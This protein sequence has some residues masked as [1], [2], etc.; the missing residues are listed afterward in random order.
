MSSYYNASS[1]HVPAVLHAALPRGE[2][3]RS[4]LRGSTRAHFLETIGR[5]GVHSWKFSEGPVRQHPPRTKGAFLLT[6]DGYSTNQEHAIQK[7]SSNESLWGTKRCEYTS[8]SVNRDF[9]CTRGIVEGNGAL[10]EAAAVL[11]Q[12]EGGVD[13]GCDSQN[14]GAVISWR[15]RKQTQSS[16]EG[17][18]HARVMVKGR[19]RAGECHE[20]C[21]AWSESNVDERRLGV[22]TGPH[23]RVGC[24]ERWKGFFRAISSHATERGLEPRVCLPGDRC[25]TRG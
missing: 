22:T 24:R 14:L 23:L 15:V 9:G 21:R 13:S 3:R 12:R 7:L 6:R 5:S 20:F 11:R 10:D 1:E 8:S 19:G 2:P 4:K 17:P 25:P 16:K 18:G